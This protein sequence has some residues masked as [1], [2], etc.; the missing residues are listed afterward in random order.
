MLKLAKFSCADQLRAAFKQLSGQFRGQSLGSV[1]LSA[2]IAT[3]PG[4]G[5]NPEDLIRLADEALY[6]AK[7]AG[8]DRIVMC[9]EQE[10]IRS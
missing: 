4:H 1:T 7:K 8:R 10:S 3:F 6:R 2:E 5:D 9:E